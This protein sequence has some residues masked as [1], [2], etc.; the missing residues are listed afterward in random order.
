MAEEQS[1]A[2]TA[3]QA[4]LTSEIPLPHDLETTLP[5]PYLARALIAP[6]T[7]HTNGTQGHD[8]NGMTL[9]QQHVT[10]F[11]QNNDRVVYPW[12]TFI[13]VVNLGS[14]SFSLLFW[15]L[16]SMLFSVFLPNHGGFLPPLPIYISNIHRAK[17]GSDSGVYDTEGRLLSKLG[18]SLLYSCKR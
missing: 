18:G 1:L 10:F 17:H 4:P 12:E 11:N 7:E 8:H 5:K 2:T 14:M 13:D 6:D 9:L 3:P 15:Q 16:I